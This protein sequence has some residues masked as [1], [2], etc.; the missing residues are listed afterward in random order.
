MNKA[1]CWYL[2]CD[3]Y[4]ED[5]SAQR[6][7]PWALGE[8]IAFENSLETQLM[9]TIDFSIHSRGCTLAWNLFVLLYHLGTVRVSNDA[10]YI[11]Y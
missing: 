5:A 1:I 3:R 11:S 8:M 10:S 6:P 7:F 2:T 4:W 9:K